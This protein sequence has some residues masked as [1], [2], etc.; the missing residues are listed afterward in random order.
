M[1]TG[2]CGTPSEVKGLVKTLAP[3]P[4]EAFGQGA[5]ACSAC[6]KPHSPVRLQN[7]L[8]LAM[9][10]EVT[11]YYS[12]PL[13][14]DEPSCRDMS[15]SLSTHIARDEAGMPHFP[16]CTVPRCKGKMCKSVR[17]DAL[18]SQLLYLKC[19]FDVQWAKSK[20]PKELK[21]ATKASGLS[22]Q[23]EGLMGVLNEQVGSVLRTSAYNTISFR[24]LLTGEAPISAF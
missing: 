17:D 10:R 16:T 24:S 5:L 19:L 3:N 8:T 4:G 11:K 14:C 6:T 1:V 23:Q 18:H 22:E 7:A 13:Q 20:Q 12:A 15:H 21:E 9:R 2:P